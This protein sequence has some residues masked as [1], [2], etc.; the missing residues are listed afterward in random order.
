MLQVFAGVFFERDAREAALLRA[1]M[2]EA[3][4][5][6]VEVTRAR[7]AAPVVRPGVSQVVL[8]LIQPSELLLTAPP[9][10]FV[11]LFL[12]SAERFQLTVPVMNHAERRA[13]AE[14]DR[15]FGHR[16]R[17]LRVFNPAADHPT[18]VDVESAVPRAD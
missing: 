1:I 3:V 11:H 9:Q 12:D 14:F 10:L 6:D 16:Q 18:D 17:V 5:A 4:F 8:K 7:A 13:E 15:A 2:D